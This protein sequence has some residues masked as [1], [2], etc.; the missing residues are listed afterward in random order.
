[1]GS[2]DWY[3]AYV[4]TAYSN[5]LIQGFED[6]EFRPNDHITREQTMVIIAKAT[7]I[8]GLLADTSSLRLHQ[9]Q[10]CLEQKLL[11]WYKHCFQNL[12]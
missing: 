1:M 6:G 4:Q 3:N 2:E 9:K 11:N 7:N 5:G 12:I 10:M 8:T